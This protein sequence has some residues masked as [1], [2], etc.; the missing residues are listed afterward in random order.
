N[1][2]NNSLTLKRIQM[3]KTI[4]QKVKPW[5]QVA[6]AFLL[7]LTFAIVS[8]QDQLANEVSAIAQQS[9]M[10]TNVPEEI[11]KHYEKLI[12]DNPEKKYLMIVK[13]DDN[14]EKIE[15]VK[16]KYELLEKAHIFR[17]DVL[18]P[19]AEPSENP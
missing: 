4:K 16:K 18:T 15:E 13:G 7:P 1:H 5:K 10:V 11:Q 9:T 19:T 3:M 14:P 17:L 8:C 12:A 2:F 6:L